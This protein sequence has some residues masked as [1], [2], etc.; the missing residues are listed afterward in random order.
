MTYYFISF[1]SSKFS[2]FPERFP[3]LKSGE[4]IK[5]SDDLKDALQ[6]DDEGRC[7]F[8]DFSKPNKDIDKWV[9]IIR[10]A[11]PEAKIIF[12]T[13]DQKP[14]DLKAHQL[15]PAGGDAYISRQVSADNLGRILT[16][17]RNELTNVRGN[18][19]EDS[20]IHNMAE[21]FE[22]DSLAVLK[23]D[24]RSRELDDIFR[25]ASPQQAP[26]PKFQ[27]I[28]NFA[29]SDDENGGDSMSDK[30]QE[31]SLDDLGDLEVSD[32]P[33]LPPD[34]PAD[35]Q[36][37][38]LDLG[39]ELD[40]DIGNDFSEDGKQDDQVQNLGELDLGGD[41]EFS[42]A[43]TNTKAKV[44][45]PDPEEDDQSGLVLSENTNAGKFDF[46][47]DGEMSPDAK[48]KL[49]EIDA[50]M[51]E[52]SKI[53][54]GIPAELNLSEDEEAG[55][56]VDFMTG[57]G[58][59]EAP[60]AD[61]DALDFGGIDDSLATSDESLDLSSPGE[62]FDLS[63]PDEVLDLSGPEES[64]DLS[65]TDEEALD[66]SKTSEDEA[67]E[68]NLADQGFEIADIAAAGT[69]EVL[70]SDLDQ[71]LVSDDLDL[72]NLDF[73]AE[74]TT[75]G[76]VKAAA[77]VVEKDKTS[78]KIKKPK[79]EA[80]EDREEREETRVVHVERPMGQELREISGAYSAE[81]ERMQATLSNLRSDREELLAKIQTLEEDKLLH[82]R[83]TLSL[84]AELDEKKIELSIVR[85]KLNEDLSEMKDR[86]RLEEERRLILEEKNRVLRE[87]LD[88]SAQKNRI[89]VK[90]VQLHERELEQRLELLKA[91]S[92]TQIRNRDLKILELK[93]KI[94]GMEFD[95]ESMQ[96]QEKR[97]VESRFE[98]EDKLEKAIK[99][100]RSAISVLEDE[101]DKGAALEALKKNIEM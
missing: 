25:E 20:G 84:R 34:A 32:T 86:V 29:S 30:D 73:G 23:A 18:K 52:D 47:L 60:E 94:D 22:M 11:H 40:I 78:T 79:K 51:D 46:S 90:K 101:T 38:D 36:G 85:K 3:A 1:D 56:P 48:E 64:L 7:F 14:Q 54:L 76:P 92:E 67:V 45:P 69:D 42:L 65:S 49:A 95:M 10:D 4:W 15:S 58:K 68:L 66:F 61:A 87:E 16:G 6:N 63:S 31:L 27:S 75:E 12:V 41:E 96:T 97:T 93:R 83:Q 71:P 8:I 39:S 91:D 72:A 9:L 17:F 62:A 82:N 99:T 57:T 80:K 33:D 98:L 21:H 74:E 89:D 44:L 88:K 59:P 43:S 5:T 50:I 70:D 55:E 2:D 19:L 13:G 100:L 26:K 53:N 37:M 77:P 24:A 81:L 28:S 35:D